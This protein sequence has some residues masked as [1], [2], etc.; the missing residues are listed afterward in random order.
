MFPPLERLVAPSS[1]RRGGVANGRG[2]LLQFAYDR[3]E[4]MARERQQS[5]RRCPI[6]GEVL[7]P[8]RRAPSSGEHSWPIA[9]DLAARISRAAFRRN[10]NGR[11]QRHR[12]R[13]ARATC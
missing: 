13:I 8:R 4:A 1:E 2:V 9:I 11:D 5:A 12:G 3:T 6:F 10:G 7:I